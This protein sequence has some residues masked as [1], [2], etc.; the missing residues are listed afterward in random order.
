LAFARLDLGPVLCPCS[1]LFGFFCG[2]FL[3]LL[4]IPVKLLNKEFSRVAGAFCMPFAKYIAW[5]KI[6]DE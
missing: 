3:L 2:A 6:G 1:L 5:G 4:R